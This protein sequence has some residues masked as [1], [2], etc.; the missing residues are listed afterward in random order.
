MILNGWI[1]KYIYQRE[2][3]GTKAYLVMDGKN[4]TKDE[5]YYLNLV[6][7]D[8]RRNKSLFSAQFYHRNFPLTLLGFKRN[9]LQF[10]VYQ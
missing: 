3:H 5:M 7:I 2:Y 10:F 4:K 8:I 9:D 6:G 1:I